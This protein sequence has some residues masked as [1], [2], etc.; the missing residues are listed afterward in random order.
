M[1]RN[2]NF[3]EGALA[4]NRVKV[5]AREKIGLKMSKLVTLMTSNAF[6]DIS[7]SSLFCNGGGLG[8]VIRDFQD[9]LHNERKKLDDSME[10]YNVCH[11]CFVV[12]KH[13]SQGR[14]IHERRAAIERKQSIVTTKHLTERMLDPE[15]MKRQSCREIAILMYSYKYLPA[16]RRG[17]NGW[18]S[19]C[20]ERQRTLTRF[21]DKWNLSSS[22]HKLSKLNGIRFFGTVDRLMV[23]APLKKRGLLL[24]FKSLYLRKWAIVSVQYLRPLQT[25]GKKC[26]LVWKQWT[27]ECGRKRKARMRLAVK[28]WRGFSASSGKAGESTKETIAAAQRREPAAENQNQTDA[29]ISGIR[30]ESGMTASVASV[31]GD[32]G[33]Q[34]TEVEATFDLDLD[35]SSL[36]PAS[37]DSESHLHSQSSLNVSASVNRSQ[38]QNNQIQNNQ[39]KN[40]GSDQDQ[41]QDNSRTDVVLMASV[42]GP[43]SAVAATTATT[44]ANALGSPMDFASMAQPEAFGVDESVTASPSSPAKGAKGAGQEKHNEK[45]QEKENSNGNGNGALSPRPAGGMGATPQRLRRPPKGNIAGGRGRGSAAVSSS[46]NTANTGIR[47]SN[48]GSRRSTSASPD[49]G[50]NPLLSASAQ[51]A[52]LEM[53]KLKRRLKQGKKGAGDGNDVKDGN[54]GKGL[55]QQKFLARMQALKAISSDFNSELQVRKSNI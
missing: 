40:N 29:E 26:F 6:L 1:K 8:H 4:K 5:N 39:N 7:E 36:C 38:I 43:L 10:G 46:T 27:G 21:F 34:Y 28:E 25:W 24:S 37:A 30:S 47:G 16:V 23:H 20:V 54:D 12:W 35:E 15:R 51:A 9:N 52:Q 33:G 53:N 44:T 11:L 19:S 45:E 48:R 18:K 55:A 32:R 14:R 2:V 17:F 13:Y 3:V 41:D 31:S 50:S 22:R 42:D 49:R